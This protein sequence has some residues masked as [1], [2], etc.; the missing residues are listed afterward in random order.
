MLDIAISITAVAFE[1]KRDRG[2]APYILHCLTVMESVSHL[3]AKA[4]M[5]GVMHDLVEDT[6]WTLDDL[7]DKGFDE[8]VVGIVD[9]LSHR[10]GDSYDEYLDRIAPCLI[11]RACKIGDL[12]HNSQI[13][14]MK[15][16]REKDFA[17]L[18]KYHRA[19]AFLKGI[20]S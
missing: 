18:A 8:E 16:L 2:G 11:S 5:A 17:R 4:M 20:D 13:H 15:G 14:R 9:R 12:D 3:G 1:G 7:R 10:D 6:D 19:Y